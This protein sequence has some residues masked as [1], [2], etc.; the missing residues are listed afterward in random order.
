MPVF[1]RPARV[2][3]DQGGSPAAAIAAIISLAV[4]GSAAAAVIADIIEALLITAVLAVLGSA[5]ILAIV[6]RRH[7]VALVQRP[8]AAGRAAAHPRPARAA[9][10]ISA[11]QPW[12]ISARRVIPGVILDADDARKENR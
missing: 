10:S 4:I 7:G 5:G 3:I 2:V 12:A 9:E 6:L 11:P 8:P 1:I